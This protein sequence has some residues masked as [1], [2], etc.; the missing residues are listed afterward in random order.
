MIDLIQ[1]NSVIP[2]QPQT[3][4]RL[5]S[6][7]PWDNTYKHVRLYNSKNDLLNSIEKYRVIPSTGLDNLSPIRI[8]SQEVRVPFTEM[9]ALNLN[10]LAF[11]NVDISNEWVF[12]FITGVMWKSEKTTVIRFEKDIFQNNFYDI[13]IKNCFIE[14][15]HIPR[16][17]DVVGG[18]L[19]PVNIETGDAIVTYK[20][21]KAFDGWKVVMYFTETP[22]GDSVEGRVA[23]GIYTAVYPGGWDADNPEEIKKLNSLIMDLTD[24]GKSDTIVA[25]VMCPKICWD[26][27]EVNA[28]VSDRSTVFEGYTPKNKKLYSYPWCYIIGDNNAGTTQMYK[29]EDTNGDL[30]IRF[31]GCL[32]TLPQVISFPVLYKGTRNYWADAMINSGFPICAYNSDTFKAWIA[33]NKSA[34]TLAAVQG[35]YN[36]FK[37]G[38]NAVSQGID[39]GK[40]FAT[41]NVA[42]GVNSTLG[43]VDSMANGIF[44][45]MSLIAEITD[46]ERM[47]SIA[48]GKALSE[49]ITVAK[50]IS[51]VTF[52]T[53][54]CRREFAEI[55]DSFFEQYGYPINKITTP[56]LNSRAVWNYIKTQNCGFTGKVDLAELGIIRSI[57]NR[58]VTLWH[59]DDIGNYSLAN[60]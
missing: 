41:L 14:Y 35:T 58:G 49:N 25:L 34:L 43:T 55:A 30:E 6:G 11:K 19:I 23:N 46:K 52:Y 32:A 2:R 60:N 36:L 9:S 4:L 1:Q 47:P 42:G 3:L 5:Y 16:S 27:K 17:A 40:N 50:N 13:K 8:G 59:T 21:H 45:E 44:G 26:G 31:E 38:V 24:A 12:C 57:F 53:M 18:N 51:G 10:Y 33:Q 48:K 15:Q 39:A 28:I 37:S 7:V 29:F 56:L 54:S 20:Y 22:E